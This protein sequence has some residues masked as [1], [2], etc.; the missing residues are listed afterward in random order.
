MKRA[1]SFFFSDCFPSFFLLF[2]ALGLTYL[3]VSL[4]LLFIVLAGEAGD[5][6]CWR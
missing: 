4:S 2:I 3:P 1:F 6:V 5:G